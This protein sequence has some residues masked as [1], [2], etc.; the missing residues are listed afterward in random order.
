MGYVVLA[1]LFEPGTVVS[2]Y[3]V[4]DETT[5]RVETHELI[6]QR[7][8]DAAGSVGFGGLPEGARYIA[9]GK[10]V[11]GNPIEE[12]ARSIPDTEGTELSQSPIRPSPQPVGTQ[13]KIP[14]PVPIGSPE[15]T[16]PVGIPAGIPLG[17]VTTT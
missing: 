11:Y 14:P 13:E 4:E 6:E 16:L 15:A 5:L 7:I 10:D 17:A 3:E 8:A 2:L 9:Q 1:G 12:R